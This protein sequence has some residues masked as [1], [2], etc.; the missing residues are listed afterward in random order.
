MPLTS[1]FGPWPSCNKTCTS[2]CHSPCQKSSRCPHFELFSISKGRNKPPAKISQSPR[3]WPP[4]PPVTHTVCGSGC[5]RLVRP[6]TCVPS[7]LKNQLHS[8]WLPRPH[9]LAGGGRARTEAARGPK[10]PPWCARSVVRAV[11]KTLRGWR[12]RYSDL[13]SW[14]I[15][16]PFYPSGRS[17]I[18]PRNIR[19]Y[20]SIDVKTIIFISFSEVSIP[21]T[22]CINIHGPALGTV[23][24]EDRWPNSR[25]WY[26]STS[27]RQGLWRFCARRNSDTHQR[28]RTI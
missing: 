2:L 5:R 28:E 25:T 19:Q 11:T 1:Y 26:L 14:L 10:T 22:R 12:L 7:S 9:S 18:P 23:N 6:H 16:A 17:R 21:A 8:T 20:Y 24:G 15:F 13:H 27:N 4:Q 3:P